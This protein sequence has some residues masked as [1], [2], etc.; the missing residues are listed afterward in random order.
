MAQPH[1][2][3]WI[4]KARARGLGGALGITLDAL[5]PLGPLGAQIL[6]VLQPVSGVFGW[7]RTVA[8]I[9]EALEEPGGIER[10]RRQL[11]ETAD[12]T[13]GDDNRR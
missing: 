4:E 1:D 12:H 8:G 9:A 13:D 10:L 11:A 7:Q 5:E 3:S 2:D 6:W